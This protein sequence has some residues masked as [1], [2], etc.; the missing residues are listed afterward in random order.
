LQLLA[1]PDRMRS[2]FHGHP[3]RSHV[4]EPLLD[5]LRGRSKATPIYDFTI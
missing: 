5:R 4:G 3:C 1:D 2:R